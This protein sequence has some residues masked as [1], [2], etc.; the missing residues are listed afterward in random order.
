[1]MKKQLPL[2]WM[3]ILCLCFLPALAGAED[4]QTAQTTQTVTALGSASVTLTPDMATFTA[5]VST[6]DTLV[7]NAQSANSEAMASVLASLK[8]M[9]IANEDLQTENYSVN[10]VYDYQSD[11]YSTPTG[12][13]VTNTVTVTV[14]DLDQLPSLLDAA[15]AAGA[16]ETYGV[17]FSSTQYN[18]AYNQALQ[19]AV[20]DALRKAG[21]MA[22]AM[23]YEIGTVRSLEETGDVYSTN[24]KSMEYALDSSAGTQIETGTISVT[25]NVTAVVEM[26]PAK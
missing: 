3:L 7:T 2:L 23:N 17:D 5:G 21:L 15:I 12:Y 4:T 10:P 18:D 16:N 26:A 6:Q 8:A 25:A 22:Q 9:G 20:Q 1:M 14:R 13:T 11:D 24:V 19:A